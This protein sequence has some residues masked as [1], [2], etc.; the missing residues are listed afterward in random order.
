MKPIRVST[1][2][3]IVWVLIIFVFIIAIAFAISFFKKGKDLPDV[4]PVST[5][6]EKIVDYTDKKL[7]E[8][9]FDS[10]LKIT[11]QNDIITL[12]ESETYKLSGTNDKYKIVINAPNK[13]VKIKLA[14]F[15][16]SIVDN[17]IKVEAASKII[18][19]LEG[20]SL[21]EIKPNLDDINNASNA[22]IIVSNSDIEMSGTG[23]LVI[24]SYNDFLR[25]EGSFTFSDATIEIKNIQT[26]LNVKGNIVVNNG[27]FYLNTNDDGFVC[28]G[29]FN[30]NDGKVIIKAT[31]KP[32]DVT[33]IFLINKGEILLAGLDEFHKP[34]ANSL[35]KSLI[36]NFEQ[37]TDKALVLHD[38][39]EV[40][41]AYEG[42]KEYKH[43]LYSKSELDADGFVLY[44]GGSIGGKKKYDLYYEIEDYLED[45]QLICPTLE[46]STFEVLELINIYNGVVKK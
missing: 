25:T 21:N 44:A 27:I 24:D 19:D 10:S 43:V 14:N 42:N 29:N 23:T 36:F 26:A 22:S 3:K 17:L 38:T 31:K 28:N 12:T 15:R 46:S 11:P 6:E 8:L 39:K 35:Q 37:P 45:Y 20:N 7:T 2:G 30:F 18:L 33:G 13:V 4:E 9:D 5:D 16:T 32:I 41:L 34:N 40:I 1:L